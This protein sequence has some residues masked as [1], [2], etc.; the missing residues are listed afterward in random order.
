MRQTRLGI[1]HGRL[2]NIELRTSIAKLCF[3][4]SKLDLC[5]TS[6]LIQLVNLVRG[7]VLGADDTVQAF[8]ID[9]FLKILRIQANR[10]IRGARIYDQKIFKF[11]FQYNFLTILDLF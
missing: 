9:R 8:G 5:C 11:P 6:R 4:C 10:M 7:Q 2:A 1:W 3:H